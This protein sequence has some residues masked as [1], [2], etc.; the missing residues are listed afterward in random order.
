M[1]A[2]PLGGA[3]G[4]PIPGRVAP[5]QAYGVS[6]TA[7]GARQ[8]ATTNVTA[9]AV[10]GKGR[11]LVAGFRGGAASASNEIVLARFTTSGK[12]DLN[13]GVRGSVI[14]G[15]GSDLVTPTAVS[16]LAPRGSQTYAVGG[17]PASAQQTSRLAVVRLGARGGLDDQFGTGGIA[18]P[19]LLHGGPGTTFARRIVLARGGR[20][21]VSGQMQLPGGPSTGLVVQL[22]Q[23]GRL[24]PGF[25]RGGRVLLNQPGGVLGPVGQGLARQPDGRIV[26]AGGTVR[27]S[28]PA[29][30]LVRLLAN[31]RRDVSFGGQ[32][33]SI[34]GG[35]AGTKDV[36]LAP[37]GTI[38]T[39][40]NASF[41]RFCANG[42][43]YRVVLAKPASGVVSFQ[44]GINVGPEN[45]LYVGGVRRSPGSV[46]SP[47][48]TRPATTRYVL[49][50][51]DC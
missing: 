50:R 28:D 12:T 39:S 38:L 44:V 20:T 27:G 42:R 22:K 7:T 35:R 32:G 41:L 2:G 10:D 13:F 18:R 46:A 23:S 33:I 24:D 5:D 25:G 3:L 43:G 47:G 31:G 11:A 36:A 30:I 14:I 49:G 40:G 1:F 29:L 8:L 26:L 15:T 9:T 17:V 48:N 34:V 51:G 19:N 45:K 16:D 21:L 37:D 6:G 4:A